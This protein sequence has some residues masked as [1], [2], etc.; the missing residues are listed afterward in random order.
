ME[1]INICKK[2]T[3]K[4]SIAA[5]SSRLDAGHS[6]EM[7]LSE[8]GYWSSQKSSSISQEYFIVDYGELIPVNYIEIAASPAG[9]A[10][11]PA[12]FRIE[13]STDGA[14]WRILQS[15]KK[16]DLEESGIYSIDFPL[17][18]VRYLKFLAIK[19]R[20][21]GTRY[22]VEIGGFAAGI[23]G[24]KSI[25]AGSFS[26]YDHDVEKLLDGDQHSYWESNVEAA[27]TKETIDIELGAVSTINRIVLASSGQTPTGF[28][29]SFL[30]EGSVDG[31]LWTPLHDQKSFFA[32]PSTR[33]CFDIVPT[34]ARFMRLH[35]NSTQ[36]ESKS[37]GVRL[38]GIELSAAHV[39][40]MHTHHMGDIT[41]HASIFQA[42]VVRLA[43]DGE[44]AMGA[45]V[46]SSDSRLRDATTT[47]KG[48]VRLAEDG[49]AVEGTAVQ[50]SDSRIQYASELKPGIV[51]FAYEREDKPGVA[52][53]GSDSRLREA[54]EKTFGIVRL[55]PDGVASEM[56]VVRGS[57]SRLKKA[58]TSTDGI[59]RLASDGETN[60]D[61]A[62]QGSDRRLK[63]GS[64][65]A[66]GIVELAEDGED[67]PNVV[68]QGN[69]RRLK[70][71]TTTSRGIV[72]L[73]EDGEDAPNVVVQGND[74]RLKEASESTK[75]IMRFARDGEVSAGA[76]VQ[77]SDRRLADS[78]T[79][80]KG[81]VELAE[82]GEIAPG[83]VVQGNDRRLR[84]GSTQ[85]K[86]IVELAEDGEDAPN[87]AVQGNDRRLKDATTTTKGIVE[88]AEDG[89]DRAGVAVQGSDRRLKEAS[90][91]T[92]GIVELAEDGEDA[93]NVA[94]QGND[95]R[96]KE[97]STFTKG[98]VELAEDGEDAPNVAVQG[99]DRRLKEA[100]TFTK[101][102]VELAE[103]GEDAPNVVV[104]GNDRRLREASEEFPGIVRL[105]RNG[106]MK[107]NACVR[108]D[109]VRLHDAR[110][111][112]AH[113]HPYAPSVHDFSIHTGTIGIVAKKEERFEGIVPVGEASAVVHAKNES[114]GDGAVGIAGVAV[115]ETET[116]GRSY[117]VLG[118]G[119]LV[120]VRGQ[121]SGASQEGLRGCGVL[122]V[123][124][125]GAGGVFASEHSFSLVVDGR[126][127]IEEFD[128]TVRLI[129]NGDA[130]SARGRSEFSGRVLV[131][132]EGG[133][134]Q[135]A[136]IVQ[137][138]ELDGSEFIQPGD[139]LVASEKG[140]SVLSRSSS[141][142]SRAVIGVVAHNP[143]LVISGT[144]ELK[145]FPVV[146]A[147][148]AMCNVDARSGPIRPGDLIVSS[149]TPGCGMAGRIDSFEKIGTVI[150][151]ALDGLEEGSGCLPIY[152]VHL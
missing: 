32:E 70:D 13:A 41:P 121:S 25:A 95:R 118:H 83:V 90:T 146:L 124:R 66:K 14:E 137:M 5:S 67:A 84:D 114:P 53:Q 45:V 15:E 86:G 62:V 91:F 131:R 11:F 94:V 87:V 38:A 74:R 20:K 81:I 99:N 148:R 88:L 9:K 1:F 79:H 132:G 103:D 143:V 96:L 112:L 31:R 104:Q 109:D 50:G 61:C 28:P 119:G 51:R 122:G 105:A 2:K 6:A 147:G 69:D 82:D 44:E 24:V 76:A 55:C 108:A 35:M 120:G 78:S 65:H 133:R 3:Y 100:S 151:K 123:S 140:S 46:Q 33:Y 54:S 59:V 89:E 73:A 22:H 80:S 116:S 27:Q 145:A 34:P 42:G 127:A 29:E 142:Y 16:F 93:P 102:I 39:S 57:D 12:D 18:L 136:D 115:H 150:G 128:D 21:S 110:K 101:G 141:A 8:E 97:A 129:G 30:I 63:Q 139:I 58:T 85:Y 138:F 7:V 10:A 23:S 130:L 64:V 4:G 134:E 126:G 40:R 106:E 49:E 135:W 98:I 19:S 43:R 117:G 26:T 48:I 47:F 60:P 92:K 72:E 125:F 37:Y 71:A 17:A 113:T 52:V 77:G 149:D 144:A 107:N 111:P 56:S 152:I 68:V 75:G 36:L